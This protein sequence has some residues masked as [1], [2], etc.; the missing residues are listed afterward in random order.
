IGL[1]KTRALIGVL[2]VLLAG[3]GTVRP[4]AQNPAPKALTVKITSPLG[5]TGVAGATR[6]VARIT[7]APGTVLSVVQFFVDGKLVGEDKDGAPYAIDWVDDNPFLPREIVVSVAD[8]SGESARDSVYLRPLEL[9]EAASVS[10]VVLEPT[11]VDKTGRPVNGLT[12]ADFTVL[13]DG[14]PQKLDLARPDIEPATYTLL[15]D[16][17]QSMARRMDFVR[18][19]ARQLPD[20][21]RPGDKVII[22]P[23]TKVVGTVTGPTNDR[24]TIIDAIDGIQ[25]GGGTAILNALATAAATLGTIDS[26]HIVVLITDGYDEHSS[27][28]F[29]RALDAI[30]KTK[31]TVYVIGIGGSAGVSLTGEGLLKRLAA[32]TGGRAFF[33]AREFQLTE[34]HGLIAADV[35]QRYVISYTPSN[36][37]LDGTWRAITVKTGTPTHVVRARSGYFAP[38]PP[39]VRP[40]IEL[41]IRDTSRRQVDISLEDLIVT[42]DGIEQQVEAFQ[43]ST[44]PVSAVL[45][46]D[47]SG[48]MR[49]DVA[50][51]IDSAKSFIDA[52]PP[53]D[54]LGVMLFADRASMTHDLST[55]REG[56]AAAIAKYQS[57]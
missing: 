56:A 53:K 30:K 46:L 29:E 48:S 43:E 45:V 13:E 7:S 31:A 37:A 23:F 54:S 21:L 12:A 10:S 27:V 6:I 4:A 15:V 2:A 9:S 19:A 44:A 55:D 5:R 11:V 26:R 16:S 24:Q 42:E 8:S 49:R 22:A 3:A 32:E 51:V 50:A 47:A 57:G 28:A 25:P 20:H 38:A 41:T 40:Q 36:Q 34:V 52:L 35:Q 1:M 39:P 18:D 33:P 14:V 17:S